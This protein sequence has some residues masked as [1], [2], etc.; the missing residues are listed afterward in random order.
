MLIQ[1]TRKRKNNF[2]KEMK[3]I[4]TICD[5]ITSDHFSN[6]LEDIVSQIQKPLQSPSSK[7]MK[8]EPGNTTLY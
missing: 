6:S 7:I 5:K 3:A 1:S 8:T 4:E 2:K